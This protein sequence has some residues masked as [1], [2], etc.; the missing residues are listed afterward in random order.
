MITCYI[1]LYSK[2]Y[3]VDDHILV[4]LIRPSLLLTERNKVLVVALFRQTERKREK[5]KIREIGESMIKR[6][7]GD[8]ER[9][10]IERGWEGET[11]QIEWRTVL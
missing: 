2:N 9:G 6:V 5:G 7:V 3:S 8:R 4:F 10:W 11:D 1:L